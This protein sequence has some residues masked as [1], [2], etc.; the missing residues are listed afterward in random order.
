VSHFVRG[1]E[2]SHLVLDI[3]HAK[4]LETLPSSSERLTRLRGRPLIAIVAALAAVSVTGCGGDTSSGTGSLAVQARWDT[5]SVVAGQTEPCEG[6]TSA[7][8]VPA[9]VES[10]RLRLTMPI[11]C[12]VAVRAP[13]T[14]AN[15]NIVITGIPPGEVA[16]SV[17][18][19]EV[20]DAPG[21]GAPRCTTAGDAGD[22]CGDDAILPVFASGPATA[23]IQANLQTN[24]T[25]LCLRRLAPPVATATPTPT[26]TETPTETPSMTPTATSTPTGTATS[27]PTETPVST[28][29][30]TETPTETPT[31]TSTQTDTPTPTATPTPSVVVIRVGSAAG[32]PGTTVTIEVSLGAAGMTV[33][34]TQ[35]EIA[36]EPEA[37]IA[38]R[39][40]GRPECSVNPAIAKNATSF[41]FL[42]PDCDVD[43]CT[44]VLALVAAFDNEDPIPDGSVLY[45]CEVE[46]AA[47]ASPGA[48]SLTC[49]PTETRFS[50]APDVSL[51]ADCNGG[52]IDVR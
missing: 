43:Q 30:A 1:P 41:S 47:N 20:P 48:K 31:P 46:I 3:D 19:F 9:E 42:P 11:Q 40:D 5:G 6:F 51:P 13:F 35:N 49:P 45:S 12:C 16:F 24:V 33:I 36:F 32:A 22:P 38:R 18:A 14:D 37:P 34:G 7:D 23:E 50:P 26:G 29:T 17:D 28:A 44:G 8:P 21:D 10:V 4:A 52:S 39:D 25:D 2:F 27:T 15:R